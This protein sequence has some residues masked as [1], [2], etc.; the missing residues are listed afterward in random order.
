MP[1]QLL[2]EWTKG[3]TDNY[4]DGA[5]S[6]AKKLDNLLLN[7]FKKLVQRPGTK[8]F[9][10]G[11]PQLPS[12]NQKI[13]S[14]YFFD[15]TCFVKSGV[16]LYYLEDGDSN[17][18]TL[19]GENGTTTAFPDSE[20]GA[21][22]SISEWRGHLF[23]TPNPGATKIA[24]CRTIKIYRDGGNN[25]WRLV[26]AGLPRAADCVASGINIDNSG[27]AH[28]IIF[29]GLE[30]SYSAKVDG[31]AVT[32][33]DFGTPMF[34]FYGGSLPITRAGITWT[35]TALDNYDTTTGLMD[36][37]EWRTK[38]AETVPLY[39]T[40]KGMG[41]S[42]V[43][44][45]S[46]ADAALGAAAYFAGG[47]SFWDPPPLCYYSAIIDGY[48]FY[49]AGIA[50]GDPNFWNTRLWQ[51]HPLN[52][53]GVPSGNFVDIPF[54]I[55]GLSHVGSYPI[56]FARRQCYRI[57]GRFDATGGGSMKAKQIS[58][59]MGCIA[60][61]AIIRTTEGIFFPSESGWCFTD[62]FK[63]ISL[64][65]H[66]NVTYKG[67][68]KDR[69]VGCLETHGNRLW[70]STE[71]ATLNPDNTGKNNC[72][73]VLDLNFSTAE[74]GVFT[75]ASAGANLLMTAMHYDAKNDRI[76]FGDQ[77]GYVMMFDDTKNN[78]LV[79]DTTNSAATWNRMGIIWD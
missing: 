75:T 39:T 58:A 30:R 35:N 59:V 34:E 71:S 8:V 51:S 5:P 36:V 10:D 17:W 18:T 9:N 47:V 54:K 37:Y 31:N 4:I 29:Y 3:I 33:Q 69:M 23:M 77:R 52:P 40:V 19:F 28:Y 26:Q 24:G 66:L 27:S 53:N 12:G 55:T 41:S 44:G 65:E 22:L 60:A 79:V 15:S 25:A 1:N 43:W 56:V 57:E 7:R 38:D 74:D 21:R 76:L 64:S 78:D 61:D 63:V 50:A 49:A 11:A 46:P 73:F 2:D 48:G 72:A 13:D 42:L 16:N 67:L 68:V 20:L 32:F 62:G 6:A 45:T 14:I 70:W